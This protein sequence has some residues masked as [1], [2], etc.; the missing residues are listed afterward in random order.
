MIHVHY[1]F[2]TQYAIQKH[3]I[4]QGISAL[5]NPFFRLH[6]VTGLKLVTLLVTRSSVFIC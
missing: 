1:A 3:Q 4:G 5:I 6:V 2:T